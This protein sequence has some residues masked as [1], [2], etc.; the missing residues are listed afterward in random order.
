MVALRLQLADKQVV[1]LPDNGLQLAHHHRLLQVR[2]AG[3]VPAG[4]QRVHGLALTSGNALVSIWI[5]VVD[6]LGL[7]PT[8]SVQGLSHRSGEPHEVP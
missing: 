3:P 5:H 1:V 6:Q 2:L 4:H 7:A 8:A